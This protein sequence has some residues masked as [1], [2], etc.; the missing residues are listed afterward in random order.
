M[1][2]ISGP[3]ADLINDGYF[4]SAGMH[5]TISTAMDEDDV[6]P[7]LYGDLNDIFAESALDDESTVTGASI[8]EPSNEAV[9]AEFSTPAVVSRAVV[10]ASVE[11]VSEPSARYR[12]RRSDK[13]VALA[14]FPYDPEVWDDPLSPG[15]RRRLEKRAE[16]DRRRAGR[17]AQRVRAGPPRHVGEDRMHRRPECTDVGDAE[18]AAQQRVGHDR[19]V[20]A[21]FVHPRVE[22]DVRALAGRREDALPELRQR[23]DRRE[24]LA[25]PVAPAHRRHNGVDETIEADEGASAREG[26]AALRDLLEGALT[27]HG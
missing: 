9:S 27:K 22:L 15:K 10:P 26:A 7:E 23:L 8:D 4:I 14:K 6:S 3:E 19:A 11:V 13:R 5:G 21:E 25:L 1:R 18:P 2:H 17:G 12:R 24:R 20:A 16:L